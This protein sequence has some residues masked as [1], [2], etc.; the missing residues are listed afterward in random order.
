MSKEAEV[1]KDVVAE[2]RFI[3]LALDE[4]SMPKLKTLRVLWNASP[5]VFKLHINP[6]KLTEKS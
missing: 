3:D 2:D 4:G 5:D 1:I 6:P